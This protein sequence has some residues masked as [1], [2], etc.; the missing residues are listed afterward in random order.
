MK[1]RVILKRVSANLKSQAADNGHTKEDGSMTKLEFKQQE[2]H[3]W[4]KIWYAHCR[5]PECVQKK[6]SRNMVLE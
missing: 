1:N 6:S 2:E 3:K 5:E 4:E